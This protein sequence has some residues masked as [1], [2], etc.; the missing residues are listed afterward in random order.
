MRRF[1]ELAH[2][3]KWGEISKDEIRYVAQTLKG[4][5]PGEDSDDNLLGTLIYILG[6]AGASEYRYLIEPYI[7]YRKNDWVCCQA[8]KA[9]CTCWG[10]TED[11]LE[12]IKMY[13]RGADWDVSDDIRIVALSIAGAYLREKFNR[14][15]MQLLVDMFEGLGE[16]EG[17]HERDD[18][19]REFLKGCAYE[20]LSRAVGEEWGYI[21]E[22]EEVVKLISNGQLSPTNLPVMQKAHQLLQKNKR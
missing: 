18:Y 1:D 10:F 2:E 21:L 14:E 22:G 4:F 16:I 19:K 9:L 11:Y 6:F 20:V 17:I 5:K 3:A 15:L 8:L 13:I 12:A 7:N